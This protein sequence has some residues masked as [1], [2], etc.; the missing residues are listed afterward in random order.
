MK[1]RGKDA[2]TVDLLCLDEDGLLK[3]FFFMLKVS[4]GRCQLSFSRKG[5]SL[6]RANDSMAHSR[7][8]TKYLKGEEND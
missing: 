3:G 2:W 4:F 6:F 7:D 8:A 1:K 5:V